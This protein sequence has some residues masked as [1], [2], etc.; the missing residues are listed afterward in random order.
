MLS[1]GRLREVLNYC[2]ETGVF[3]WI[4]AKYGI[5]KVGDI[6]GHTKDV[7]MS[8]GY[9]CI[10]IDGKVY[11]AHRLAW[12][13]VHGYFPEYPIDHINRNRSDNR[14][15]NLRE[16]SITCNLRNRSTFKNSKSGITGVIYNELRNKWEPSI[17][18]NKNLKY[19]G[20]HLDFIEAVC[21]RLAAEQCLGWNSCNSNSDAH[22]TIKNYLKE[23]THG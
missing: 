14:L 19:L 13:F 9:T 5:V 16:I 1:Q 4:K 12:L 20:R 3:T 10:V 6:A 2:P 18:I 11:F 15:D 7:G 21:V 22:N 23:V 17:R 8:A